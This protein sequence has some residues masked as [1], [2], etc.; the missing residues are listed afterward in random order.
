VNLSDQQGEKKIAQK[1]ANLW[2]SLKVAKMPENLGQYLYGLMTYAMMVQTKPEEMEPVLEV[3]M[4][5]YD[6]AHGPWS[7]EPHRPY[8]VTQFCLAWKK[9]NYARVRVGHK[10][11]HALMLTSIP[12]D[13]KVR[14]P[15]GAWVLEVPDGVLN[16]P[17]D[18]GILQIKAVICQDDKPV[19]MICIPGGILLA[20]IDREYFG[21]ILRVDFA[22]NK[23][24]SNLVTSYVRGVCLAVHDRQHVQESQWGAT[25]SKRASKE[26][27]SGCL[28]TLSHPVKID[29]KDEVRALLAGEKRGPL[30]SQHL[31]RGHWRNQACGPGSKEHRPAWIEPHWKGPED[32]RIL[33]RDYRI[34]D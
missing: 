26:P 12:Q 27:R 34:V 9:S 5:H 4:A 28:L 20:D 25:G 19:S 7:R 33:L 32:A 23:I 10:L 6:F 21:N 30:K 15:W 17:S 18:D 16:V 31:V 13:M 14:S 2:R 24:S 11:A 3:L 29:F 8:P 22:Y 1:V